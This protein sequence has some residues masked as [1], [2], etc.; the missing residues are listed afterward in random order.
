[1]PTTSTVIAKPAAAVETMLRSSARGRC[2]CCGGPTLPVIEWRGKY[3]LCNRCGRFCESKAGVWHHA[4]P[5]RIDW[6]KADRVWAVDLGFKR[7]GQ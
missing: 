2:A 4:V 7:L 3:A 6:T 1:M 5:A